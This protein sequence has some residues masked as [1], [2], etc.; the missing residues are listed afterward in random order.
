M[1]LRE[2][3]G[4]QQLTIQEQQAYRAILKAFSKMSAYFD[5]T[6]LSRKV[7]L[8]KTLQVAL[9]DN[10]SVIYFN[11]TNATKV[12]HRSTTRFQF[13]GIL[14]QFEAQKMASRLEEKVDH[15]TSKIESTAHTEYA[16]LTRIYE[17]LQENVH[18]DQQELANILSA[19]SQRTGSENP[20]THNAYGALVNNLAV[21]D[22][23]SSAFTLLAQKL[24]IECTHIN[25][26]STH[27]SSLVSVEH[28]WNIIKTG[29]KYYHLD[30]TWDAAQFAELKEYSYDYFALDDT[31]M[32]AD[33]D[34]DKK[35][36]LACTSTDLSYYIKNGLFAHSQDHLGDL[37]RSFGQSRSVPA[38]IKIAPNVSLRI[39]LQ[40]ILSAL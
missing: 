11:K 12:S 16:K 33:H 2:G 35:S 26:F 18:Y 31:Q 32:L 28:A 30:V 14:P 13:E 9:A 21:C 39:T 15:I 3:L 24:G 36:V 10:P 37:A 5:T 6:H 25:G 29:G 4:F 27:R 38:R 1:I 8:M 7:D 20:S 17:Y 40:A 22:G 23:F 19:R 34:W